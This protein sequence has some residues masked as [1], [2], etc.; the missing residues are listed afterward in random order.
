MRKS[1]LFNVIFLVFVNFLVKPFWVF[2]IDRSI[3]NKLGESEYGIYFAV[4]NFTYLFQ[5]LLDFGL[6]NYNARNVA[7]DV[8]KLNDLLPNILLFKTILFVLY[9]IACVSFAYPLGYTNF[10]FLYVIIINHFLLS[11][12]IY[13]RSNVSAHQYFVT[14]S[15][16]SVLD[17]LLMIFFCALLIWGKTNIELTILNFTLAQL[18]AYAITFIICLIISLRLGDKLKFTISI[19][20]LFS[21]IKTSAPYAIAYFL[22][23]TYYRIDGV[24]LEQM[25]GRTETGIYAQGY[26]IIESINNIGYLFS[27]ILLPIFSYYIAQ[28]K[29]LK[30]ILFPSLNIILV[31]IVA[32]VG[33]FYFQADDIMKLL[34]HSNQAYSAKVFSWLIL[35]FIPIGLL[36]VLGTL[37]TAKESFRVMLPTLAIAV[38]LNI[39]FNYVLIK[40]S[41]AVGAAQATLFTQLFVLFVYSIYIFKNL[42]LKI[43]YIKVIKMMLF[44]ALSIFSILY[45]NYKF[46][47]PS[48]FSIAL[49]SSFYLVIVGIS[50]IIFGIINKDLLTLETGIR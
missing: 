9:I 18:F 30:E 27:V 15:L 19:D 44:I 5:I 45:L 39:I 26:R 16:L 49:R 36:Y 23:T 38:L 2:G 25:S 33:L 1:F 47:D 8:R 31:I 3:Q 22:M 37:L 13:L 43:N 50:A 11:F 20:K 34:Y 35:N 29:N 6:Q 40:K 17:K 28:Y 14:D 48:F 12:I 10:S 4:F 42:A 46:N 7:T 21:I 24:M 41:G 32:V